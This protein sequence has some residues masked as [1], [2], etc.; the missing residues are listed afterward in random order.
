MR[1]SMGTIMTLRRATAAALCSL[2]LAGGCG[3]PFQLSAP[4]PATTSAKFNAVWDGALE[5]LRERDF[6]IDRTDRRAGVI[7]TFPLLGRHWFEFW[8]GDAVA[9]RDVAEGTVQTIYRQVTVTIRP[10]K[11]AGDDPFYT[12]DVAVQTSRSDLPNVRI[13]STSEA[14]ELFTEPS[15]FA[16]MRTAPTASR[17]S[18]ALQDRG[19][20]HRFNVTPVPV[21]RDEALEAR[22]AEAIK[23]RSARKL[24]LVAPAPAAP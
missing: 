10:V 24:A 17:R 13:T 15:V 9:R 7:T 5:I 12:A 4:T 20:S 19:P 2:A 22:L 16:E 6:R 14:Y 18:P 3:H 21:A 11:G 23:G 1:Y 8:R